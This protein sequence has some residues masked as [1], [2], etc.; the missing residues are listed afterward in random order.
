MNLSMPTFF[1]GRRV[2]RT[3]STA[4]PGIHARVDGDA[5]GRSRNFRFLRRSQSLPGHRQCTVAQGSRR[6]DRIL[7]S[8][9]TLS[10]SLDSSS[11]PRPEIDEERRNKQKVLDPWRGAEYLTRKLVIPVIDRT[12]EERNPAAGAQD[13]NMSL[14]LAIPKKCRRGS[15]ESIDDA[16]TTAMT[17]FQRTGSRGFRQ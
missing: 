5:R 10:T 8:T 12:L 15:E 1:P 2:S 3:A 14:V 16:D 4:K 13:L 9:A 6:C 17:F 7:P 11:F